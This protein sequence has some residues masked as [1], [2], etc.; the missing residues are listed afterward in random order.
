MKLTKE[1]VEA[2]KVKKP[3]DVEVYLTTSSINGKCNILPF[4][5]PTSIRM[6]IS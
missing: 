6:S 4:F 3:D 1:I 5:S 2:L